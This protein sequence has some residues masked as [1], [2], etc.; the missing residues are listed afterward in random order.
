MKLSEKQREFNLAIAKLII[1]ANRQGYEFT[2][3]DAVGD[4][5]GDCAKVRRIVFHI[6]FKIFMT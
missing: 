4:S 1:W 6:T 3:G 2:F 5:T